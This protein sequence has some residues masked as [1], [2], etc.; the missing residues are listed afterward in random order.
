MFDRLSNAIASGGNC[1]DPP[2]PGWWPGL[3]PAM[4]AR[5]EGKLDFLI[6]KLE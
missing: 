4:G 2:G 5:P 6:S 3:L 1:A